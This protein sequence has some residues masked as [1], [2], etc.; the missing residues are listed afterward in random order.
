M[1]AFSEK[2]GDDEI[3]ALLSYIRNS[4]GNKEGAVSADQ[5]SKQR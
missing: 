2:L 4:W 5:V 3:A 1:P